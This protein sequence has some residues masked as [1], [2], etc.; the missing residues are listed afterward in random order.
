MKQNKTHREKRIS[1]VA[2]LLRD[3]G[4]GVETHGQNLAHFTVAST[5]YV[6]RNVVVH[7]K[8]E[9]QHMLNVNFDDLPTSE[10]RSHWYLGNFTR[11]LD[12]QLGPE[13]ADSSG[14]LSLTYAQFLR[15]YRPNYLGGFTPL[16]EVAE[17]YIESH[18]RTG[19]SAAI[20]AAVRFDRCWTRFNAPVNERRIG[21]GFAPGHRYFTTENSAE[22]PG[23]KYE[24]FEDRGRK[25]C[26]VR[27]AAYLSDGVEH[28]GTTESL[29]VF[30]QQCGRPNADEMCEQSVTSYL[31]RRFSRKVEEL[32][33]FHCSP[34]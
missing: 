14:T 7:T 22:D 16:C 1:A 34:V 11:Y 8:N 4:W 30:P 24:I 18:E 27:W 15:R 31:E 21:F 6:P 25:E 17:P 5:E 9:L 3:L 20:D 12:T 28:P 32:S 29:V 26:L 23:W 19:N 2:R 33:M 13:E 10:G